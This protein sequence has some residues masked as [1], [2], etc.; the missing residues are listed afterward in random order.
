ML[1]NGRQSYLSELETGRVDVVTCADISRNPALFKR[2]QEAGIAIEPIG[3]MRG[4]VLAMADHPL[5]TLPAITSDDLRGLSVCMPDSGTFDDW[6]SCIDTSIGEGLGLNYVL[7]SVNGNLSNLAYRDFGASI[8]IYSEEELREIVRAR[9][10]V[11]LWNELDG[12]PIELPFAL[13]YR[14]DNENKN[15]DQFVESARMF[16][17]TDDGK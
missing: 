9:N 3:K 8:F 14:F 5:A 17:G 16:F 12:K 15:L 6:S 4:A 13:L 11:V 7:M 2:A 10:D 1:A